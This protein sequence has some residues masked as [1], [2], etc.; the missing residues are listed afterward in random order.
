M[1]KKEPE[2]PVIAST[3]N[4]PPVVE[5]PVPEKIVSNEPKTQQ[6]NLNIP[7]SSGLSL[8]E[9]ISIKSTFE[10]K[11]VTEEQLE[12]LSNKPRE[13]FTEEALKET[14][15]SFQ[16]ILKDKGKASLAT[17]FANEP[18]LREENLLIVTL[19]NKALEEEFEAQKTDTLDYLR[20]QLN[21]YAIQIETVVNKD[22]SAKVAY[23]PQEKYVKMSTKNPNLDQFRKRFDLDVG[24]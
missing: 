10:Q 16:Q 13:N 5:Q 1:V 21:N 7:L 20:K 11:K 23:T 14:W 4:V 24:Y 22:I 15:K 12:V 3:E 19:E 2:E 8:T 9:S 17:I 18:E 6:K